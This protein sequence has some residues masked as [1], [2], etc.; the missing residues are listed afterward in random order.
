MS[1]ELTFKHEDG[2]GG[3]QTITLFDVEP[4]D[5]ELLR[6]HD[7]HGAYKWFCTVRGEKYDLGFAGHTHGENEYAKRSKAATPAT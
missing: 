2:W 6:Y 1:K 7:G 5:V 4:K 3:V